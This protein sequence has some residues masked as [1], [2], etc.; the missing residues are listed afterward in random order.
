MKQIRFFQAALQTFD[1]PCA[2]IEQILLFLAPTFQIAIWDSRQSPS[3]LQSC[4]DIRTVK[5]PSPRHL[6]HLKSTHNR[7]SKRTKAQMWRDGFHRR[8]SCFVVVFLLFKQSRKYLKVV[9]I[10]KMKMLLVNITLGFILF[11][12]FVLSQVCFV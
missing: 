5:S 7:P 1:I 12:F 8:F 2:E 4:L 6:R 3:C 11:Y 10:S 9:Y